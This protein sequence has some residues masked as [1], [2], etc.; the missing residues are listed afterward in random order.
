VKRSKSTELNVST[1]STAYTLMMAANRASQ[2][3]LGL[4]IRRDKIVLDEMRVQ[5]AYA[6]GLGKKWDVFIYHATED[7]D[8]FVRPLA[9]ALDASGLS[10]WYDEFS[11][12]VGDSLRAKIDEQLAN[13]RYG[14]VVLSNSFFAKNSPQHEL[15]GLMSSEIPGTKVILPVWHH[16]SFEEVREQNRRCFRD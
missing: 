7:K 11:L 16:I 12:K 15:D 14:V 1:L 2:L 4:D 8:G 6:A 5:K 13:S 10:V 3:T 9:M